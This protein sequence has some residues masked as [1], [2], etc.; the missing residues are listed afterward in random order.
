[1]KNVKNTRTDF[2]KLATMT[3]DEI[4][5]SDIPEFT[6]EFLET[7]DGFA[8][9]PEKEMISIRIDKPILDFYRKMGKGYQ[10]RINAVLRAYVEMSQR[11]Q[12]QKKV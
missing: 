3:D 1:M 12:V 5:C 2:E 6:E 11:K 9:I 4:D 7:V 10:G 8:E